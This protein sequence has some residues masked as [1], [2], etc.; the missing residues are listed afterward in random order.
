M[1]LLDEKTFQRLGQQV[2]TEVD[3]RVVFATN[4]DLPAL[5]DAG[6][7]RWDLLDRMEDDV[8]RIPA[9]SEHIEDL[10]EIAAALMVKLAG[11]AHVEPDILSP[12]ELYRLMSFAW[13][14]NVRQLE[15]ALKQRIKYGKLPGYLPRT[16]RWTVACDRALPRVLKQV[17][18]NK[19]AAARALAT[20]RKTL[21]AHLKN[22]ASKAR[23]SKAS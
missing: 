3:V 4:E 2:D 6:R 14:G 9:L 15:N 1:D 17:H 5:A 19:S 16:R 10:P 23:P 13:P 12:L 8:I 21:Y 20:S 7:F 11:E 18:G 22:H